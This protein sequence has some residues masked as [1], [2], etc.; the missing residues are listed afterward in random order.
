MKAITRILFSIILASVLAAGWL[1]LPA[2]APTNAAAWDLIVTKTADTNDG[3]CDD[4]D[5]SLREAIS[6]SNATADMETIYVPAGTYNLYR[7]GND[8]NNAN[9]DL[10]ITAG[11][12]ITGAGS[13]VTIITPSGTGE[14]ALQIHSSAGTVQLEGIALKNAVTYSDGGGIHISGA[15][16][17][18]SDVILQGNYIYNTTYN[19][20]GMFITG[21]AYVAFSQ[22]KILDNDAAH[23]GGIYVESGMVDISQSEVSD[24][25]SHAYGAGHGGGI[26]LGGASSE[27][28]IDTSTIS[29]NYTDM[30]GGGMYLDNG[31]QV[32]ISSSTISGNRSKQF[33]GGIMTLIPL[34]IYHSTVT[35]NVGDDDNVMGQ[36]V[37]GG[38]LATGTKSVVFVD[39]SIIAGNADKGSPDSNDCLNTMANTV[40]SLGYNLV[41]GKVYCSS[42]NTSKGDIIGAD[43]QLK[44]LGDYGGPTMTHALLWGSPARD[45]GDSAFMSPPYDDQRGLSRVVG[46]AID[47]GAVEWQD[48]SMW[49]TVTK[50]TDTLD[51]ECSL[52]DCSLREAVQAANLTHDTTV[53]IDLPEATYTL[54]RAGTYDDDNSTG[55]LDIKAPIKIYGTRTERSIINANGID[56]ALELHST[57]GEV[58]L[59]NLSIR[60]G[61]APDV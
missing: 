35:A 28:V 21:G 13:A 3:S 18:T 24:N 2:S 43:P 44:P 16:L 34:N 42:F 50:T 41:G 7:V 32:T 38:L 17:I 5:C 36:F 6:A 23:G 61:Y 27:M 22:S 51:G 31:T 4:S 26:F 33:T 53:I 48:Y 57:A 39:H 46:G 47:I 58:W 30:Y 37:G 9:G 45:N 52:T 56:R 1:V 60:G 12:S 25:E 55:D 20:G 11:V 15:M 49:L 59:H 10:D 14:R 19:G 54:S 40:S 8:D 29:G